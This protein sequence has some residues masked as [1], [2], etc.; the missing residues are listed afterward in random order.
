M[1]GRRDISEFSDFVNTL[2]KTY[3]L[4]EYEEIAAEN[5]KNAGLL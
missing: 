3:G 2:Y 1:Y 4:G 5:L